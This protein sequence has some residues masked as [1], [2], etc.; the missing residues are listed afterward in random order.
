MRVDTTALR[1]LGTCPTC[2]NALAITTEEAD[3]HGAGAT[4]KTTCPTCGTEATVKAL[5]GTYSHGSP[6]DDRCMYAISRKCECACAGTNHGVG[7]IP[8]TGYSVEMVTKANAKRKATSAKRAATTAAKRAEKAAAKA[9]AKADAL[10]DAKA[11]VLTAY[12]NLARLARLAD[13]AN[14]VFLDD[15]VKAFDEGRMTDRQAAAASAAVA[16]SED[17][18]A[19]A[20]A[21]VEAKAAALASGVTAPTGRVDLRVKVARVVQSETHYTFRGEVSTRMLVEH[22]DG[23]SAW[24]TVP[25]ALGEEV[26][27]ALTGTGAEHTS[28]LGAMWKGLVGREIDLKVTLAAGRDV[29]SPKATRP[30]ARLAA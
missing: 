3:A 29:L 10:A 14:E 27:G 7:Y 13:A 19:R 1:Y 25:K 24:M 17:R 2:H 6:C 16:R 28:Y 5:H 21:R 12:P 9:Q 4:V 30:E 26:L 23:W 11:D 15:M 8:I 18:A 20:A 22:A